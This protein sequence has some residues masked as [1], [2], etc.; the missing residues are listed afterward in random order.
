MLLAMSSAERRRASSYKPSP[1]GTQATSTSRRMRKPSR[2]AK[3][4]L[5]EQSGYKCLCSTITK[6]LPPDRK[7]YKPPG[8]KPSHSADG[9]LVK[10][11]EFYQDT[12]QV[13]AFHIGAH[14]SVFKVYRQGECY[15]E[16]C[17]IARVPQRI[18]GIELHK[19]S[20]PSHLHL[21]QKS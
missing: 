21:V 9:Q 3:L 13:H 17:R 7:H 16:V 8:K 10:A 1:S 12:Q 11:P 5:E 4:L 15:V 2:R 20:I 14:S 18:T 19:F 6:T